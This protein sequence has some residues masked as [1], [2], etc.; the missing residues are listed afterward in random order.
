MSKKKDKIFSF[1]TSNLI[2]DIIIPPLNIIQ[3]EPFLQYDL[4]DSANNNELA[5]EEKGFIKLLLTKNVLNK[6]LPKPENALPT[7]N[8]KKQINPLVGLTMNLTYNTS[9]AKCLSIP[10]KVNSV[11]NIDC[12][13]SSITID[14]EGNGKTFGL[15]TPFKLLINIPFTIMNHTTHQ[16]EYVIIE[17]SP[18][19]CVSFVA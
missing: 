8:K 4:A 15:I 7:K 13:L 17:K 2:T 3:P 9:P 19:A 12:Y 14:S 16:K 10:F 18:E 11:G 6:K 5:I 1:S